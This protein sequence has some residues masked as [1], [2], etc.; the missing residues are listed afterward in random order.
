M[1]AQF[2]RDGLEPMLAIAAN[3]FDRPSET[4]IRAHVNHIMPGRVVLLCQHGDGAVEL[5]CPVLSNLRQSTTTGGRANRLINALKFRWRRY[6]EPALRG[7]DAKKVR[8]F[9]QQH[10]VKAV[11]AEYG[12]NG[13]LLRAACRRA[14]VPLFVHFHGF[15]ATKLARDTHIARHYRSLFRDAAGIIA[16][17]KFLAERIRNLGCP[18]EKLHISPNGI[19]LNRFVPSCRLPSRIVAVSRLV[20]VKGPLR[21]IE[22]FARVRN[23]LLDATLDIVGDG[24]LKRDCLSLAETLGVAD[25]ITF[26]GAQSNEYV[27]DLM[28]RAS[29][30]VQHSVTT[31]DGQ[32]ESFGITVLEAAASELPVVVTRSGGL[33]ETVADGATGLL[34]AEHDVEGMAEAMISLLE[35]PERAVHMGRAGRARVEKNFTHERA[36]ARLREIMG[37]EL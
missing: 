13:S 7:R 22:A 37:L 18:H 12:P 17:S 1:R 3:R 10:A 14:G 20:P 6:V 9:L 33:E 5:G 29:L 23:T 31:A 28:S 19:E 2:L 8:V 36:A 11:L 35:D 24:A 15:D 34:V 32:A 25:A 4:F 30:F 21:T 27:A 16:P 26:H